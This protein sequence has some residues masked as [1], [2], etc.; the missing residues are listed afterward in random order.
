MKH[1]FT[2]PSIK[3]KSL[4]MIEVVLLLL[5]SLGTLFFF[6]RK[7]LVMETKKDANQ[8]LEGT[9][10]HVDN[11][12]LSIEQTTGNF[13]F[14]LTAH[15]DNPE[16]M[17]DY[18]RR[19]VECNDYIFG[20][21]IAFKPGYY[22]DRDLFLT[23]AHRKK[24]NSPELILSDKTVTRPYTE[25]NWYKETMTACRPAWI[26]PDMNNS[27]EVEPVITFCLPITNSSKECV[28]VIAVG[29]SINMFSQNVL[30]TKPSPNSYS[31]LLNSKGTYII[32]PDRDK[33]TGQTI[34]KQPE[35]AESPTAIEAAKAMLKGESGDM[36][37]QKNNETWYLFY[38]PFVRKNI[39]GRSTEALN[40]SIAT[41]YPKADIFN[42]YNHLVLHVIG[43]ALAGL[44]VFYI[45]CK[46]AIRKQLKPLAYL[47]ESAKRIANGHYDETI[48][49]TNR[50]DEVGVF[51]RHFLLMQK[52]LA[53]DLA[54]QEQQKLTL[55]ERR[56]ELQK[57]Y[58]QIQDDDNVKNTFL[59][60]VTNRMIAPSE[61]ICNSVNNLCD[62]YQVIT[63][64]EA[65]KEVDNIKR[66]S[67]DIR[68]LL[69]HKFNP[70][71]HIGSA[72]RTA[73]MPD[74]SPVQTNRKEVPNE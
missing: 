16:R 26:I 69:S 45:L 17:K 38:K 52:A 8:R 14:E 20:S 11:V 33:L 18:C 6:T 30:E 42:E 34:F 70:T 66:K 43:I 7:A 61:S 57:T 41:I 37:F 28:G 58:Q 5:V 23:Y 15:L 65:Q 53:A 40:W 9:V 47:T 35:I 67:E 71:A 22:P 46:M 54:K 3:L 32:H 36:S 27:Y 64:E 1:F 59:H 2:T 62:N 68:E 72:D 73:T 10:Q 60:N 4:V 49:D 31:I 48:P 51:Q 24:Y 63:V 50:D 56:E 44:L 39:P 55:H 19:L 74:G 21:A 13:Y 29:L 12:L 25:Q